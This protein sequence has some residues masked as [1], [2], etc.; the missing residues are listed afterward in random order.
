MG[1]L[2]ASAY[3]PGSGVSIAMSVA[4]NN[5]MQAGNSTIQY[6]LTTDGAVRVALNGL[7]GSAR[8]QPLFGV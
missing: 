5:L 8:A 7:Y 6:Q 1:D 2:L 3:N 4:G